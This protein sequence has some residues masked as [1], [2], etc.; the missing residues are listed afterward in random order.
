MFTIFSMLAILED[1]QQRKQSKRFPETLVILVL[2][3]KLVVK[4]EIS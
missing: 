2:G 1:R 4:E 3:I